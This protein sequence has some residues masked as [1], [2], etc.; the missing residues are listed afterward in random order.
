[1]NHSRSISSLHM[2]HSGFRLFLRDIFEIGSIIRG[3]H[4]WLINQ[5][6]VQISAKLHL[7]TLQ[8]FFSLSLPRHLSVLFVLL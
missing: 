3:R 7:V 1:M 4:G 8:A 5:D 6:L 2:R